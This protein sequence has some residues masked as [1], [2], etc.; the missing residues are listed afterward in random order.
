[1]SILIF[2]F[3][4]SI[5][6]YSK[7]YALFLSWLYFLWMNSFIGLCLYAIYMLKS[8]KKNS[9]DIERFLIQN[10]PENKV[11]FGIIKYMRLYCSFIDYTYGKFSDIFTVL[12]QYFPVSII[13]R[14]V[15]LFDKL[16]ITL[17]N[18]LIDTLYGFIKKMGNEIMSG[19]KQNIMTVISDDNINTQST[20]TTDDKMKMLQSLSAMTGSLTQTMGDIIKMGEI[21]GRSTQ[22][23]DRKHSNLLDRVKANIE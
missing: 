2:I 18:T 7:L 15:M 6:Y 10:D 13:Y 1:M 19:V 20:E 12:I 21:H 8:I 3:W 17:K 16:L 4:L 23:R 9:H 22:P 5:A 14:C 11:S